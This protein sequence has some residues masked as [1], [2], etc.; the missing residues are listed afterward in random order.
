MG[1]RQRLE[2]LEKKVRANR[3][4]DPIDP[5]ALARSGELSAGDIRYLAG[6]FRE[7][8]HISEAEEL[9]A[10]GKSRFEK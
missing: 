6:Y 3:R 7:V 10:I 1:I 8:G 2:R 9:E 5:F 4:T